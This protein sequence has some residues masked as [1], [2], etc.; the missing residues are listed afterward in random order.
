MKSNSPSSVRPPIGSGDAN[1]I[2][3]TFKLPKAPLT[4]HLVPEN[5]PPETPQLTV[6]VDGRP[7]AVRG[8]ACRNPDGTWMAVS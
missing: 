2:F 5:T 6:Y 1:Q 7:Q 3:Q 4:Y 8:T